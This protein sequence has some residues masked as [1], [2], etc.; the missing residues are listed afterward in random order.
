MRKL[1]LAAAA[2]ALGALVAA[3]GSSSDGNASV[4]AGVGGAGGGLGLDG[5]TGTGSV[6]S[7]AG[8]AGG[9]GALGGAT[10]TG[11]ERLGV[12]DAALPDGVCANGKDDD[13]DGLV[14]FHDPECTGPLD[15]DESSF[16]TGIPGDNVDPKWQDCFFDG[17][18]G[19]GDDGCRY[20]TDCLT[21]AREQSDRDCQVT[22]QCLEFCRPLAPNGCDCF[23]CCEVHGPGGVVRTVQISAT[24]TAADVNDPEKCPPCTQATVCVNDCETCELCVGKDTLPAE[25]SPVTPPWDGGTGAGGAPSDDGG[26][27]PTPVCSEGRAPCGSDCLPSCGPDEYCLTGCCVTAPR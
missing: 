3:C 27:C 22:A 14:D 7:G 12:G 17:N 13:G 11:G 1:Q 9:A 20:H 10:G 15:D 19:A 26:Y 4:G 23:G 16:A 25:C 24:C 5:S 18:S 21:G 6:A 8:G 2:A